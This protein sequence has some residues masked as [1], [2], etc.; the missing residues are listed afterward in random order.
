[1]PEGGGAVSG[2]ALP[3]V[4]IV[5]DHPLF[6]DGV[7]A[8]L[9]STGVV[10]VVGTAADGEQALAAVAQHDP[11]VVL[12][13]VQM[14]VLDGV[15]ATRRLVDA[16]ARAAVV[17]LT[18]SEED[19]TVFAA[20]RAGARGYLLKG[21]GQEELVA[22]VRTAATGG[23]VFGAALAAR[24][25]AFFAAP[26]AP[27][28]AAAAFPELTAREAEVLEQLAAGRTNAEIAAALFLSPKTV[29]NVVSAVL[30]KLQAADRTEAADRAREAGVAP[31]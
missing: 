13:D 31:R 30:A 8:L 26:P 25:A 21:A 18:M 22:A 20:V 5:D 12:M 4:L 27:P 17:V 10:E 9:A 29:R 3:R 24:M 16:R 28:T 6:R 7:A 14:P 1:M 19:A 11:D 23:A 15:A 2:A